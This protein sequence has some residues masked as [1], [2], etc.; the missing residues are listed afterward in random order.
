MGD[1]NQNQNES[2][3]PLEGFMSLTTDHLKGLMEVDTA[4]GKPIELPN[5]KTLIP[6]SHVKYGFATGGSEFLPKSQNNQQESII[7]FG[8]GGGGSV[9]VTPTAFLLISKEKVELL[10]LQ[11]NNTIHHTKQAEKNPDLIQQV[12]ELL[13]DRKEKG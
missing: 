7:P 8:G 10:T 2:Q 5:D 4:V 12:V 9:S 6:L 1:N 13:K 3:H 11:G